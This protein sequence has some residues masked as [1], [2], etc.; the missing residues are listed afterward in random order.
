[1]DIIEAIFQLFGN[2]FFLTDGESIFFLV[3]LI[4]IVIMMLRARKFTKGSG[5]R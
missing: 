3:L 4:M 5:S 2:W 1:M